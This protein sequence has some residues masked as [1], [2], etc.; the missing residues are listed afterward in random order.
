MLLLQLQFVFCFVGT[1]FYNVTQAD[2]KLT[3]SLLPS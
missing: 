1:G 3:T 2:L